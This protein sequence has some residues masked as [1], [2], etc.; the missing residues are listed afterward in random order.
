MQKSLFEV[1]TQ[2]PYFGLSPDISKLERRKGKK[3]FTL[4]YR[5]QSVLG[6]QQQKLQGGETGSRN[7]GRVYRGMEYWCPLSYFLCLSRSP[8]LYTLGLPAQGWHPLQWIGPSFMNQQSRKVPQMCL[9]EAGCH[10]RVSLPRC[11]EL[12]KLINTS[13]KRWTGVCTEGQRWEPQR[14][15]GWVKTQMAEISQGCLDLPRPL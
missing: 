9:M 7:P 12:T 8:Y 5:L 2:L 1:C 11:A 15:H 13:S 6:V 4:V 3:K 10:S 14:A